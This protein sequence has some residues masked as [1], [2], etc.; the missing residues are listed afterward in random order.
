M[1]RRA[2]AVVVWGSLAL[3]LIIMTSLASPPFSGAPSRAQPP[4]PPAVGACGELRDGAL[5]L[6]DCAGLHTVEVVHAQDATGPALTYGFCVGEVREFVGSPSSGED[7]A[8]SA[9]RWSLPLRYSARLAAGPGT[10]G[11]PGWSWRACVVSPV[12]P[13]P[14]SGY[15]GS[16]R[17]VD[18]LTRPAAL[19]PCFAVTADVLSV[20][21]CTAPHRGEIV[22][23]QL[24]RSP[25]TEL[26]DAETERIALLRETSCRDAAAT[27][28][29]VGDP[30]YG[31]ELRVVVLPGPGAPLRGPLSADTGVY[32]SSESD[33]DWLLCT[34]QTAADVDL[35]DS[36]AGWGYRALPLR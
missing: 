23:I 9:G 18:P 4:D 7:G 16:V 28:A 10:V 24:V 6:V 3:V 26:S 20:L 17:D 31:A 1:D 27:F 25:A 8:Y 30:T 2:V 34:L 32:Y 36:L 35:V 11:I 21:P 29:G 19:R 12:G 22:G 13:A 33:R 14:W 5:V 15:R